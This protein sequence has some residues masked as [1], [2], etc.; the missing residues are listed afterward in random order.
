MEPVIGALRFFWACKALCKLAT[1][2]QPLP[3][4]APNALAEFIFRESRAVRR[5]GVVKRASGELYRIMR[6]NERCQSVQRRALSQRDL[7]ICL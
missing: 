5:V 2:G 3:L 6:T 1:R 7:F 4:G